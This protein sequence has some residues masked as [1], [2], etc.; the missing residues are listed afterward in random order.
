MDMN[1]IKSRALAEQVSNS[2]KLRNKKPLSVSDS[3]KLQR[4][5]SALIKEF[6]AKWD[7]DRAGFGATLLGN[8][9]NLAEYLKLVASKLLTGEIELNSVDF[10][11][12]MNLFEFWNFAVFEPL[13]D[14]LTYD[15]E[16]AWREIMDSLRE[17]WRIFFGACRVRRPDDLSEILDG[18][19][20]A[21]ACTDFVE[22]FFLGEIETELSDEYLACGQLLKKT[23]ADMKARAK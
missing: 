23:L 7:N 5:A 22:L 8:F 10:D 21:I 18:E 17:G 2:T 11:G 15:E 4:K 16:E 6:R 13:A 9:R 20:T 3:V 14:N 19:R 12:I 1:K